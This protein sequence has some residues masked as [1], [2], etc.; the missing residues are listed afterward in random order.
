[1]TTVVDAGPFEKRLTLVV[2][3]QQLEE[4][5]GQAARKLG[6]DLKIPGFRPGRAP[7]QVVEATLGADRIRSEAI[8]TVLP[9]AVSQ[10]LSEEDLV[11]AARPQ[12]EKIED[13]ENGV[14]VEV[15]VA[16]WPALDEIPDYEGRKIE[17]ESPDITDEELDS[18][19][20]RLREQF[21][22]LET[23]GREAIVGDYIVLD[24]SANQGGVIVEEA[25]ANDLLYEVGS[26]LL[27]P[28]L[29]DH[30]TGSTAGSILSFDGA[31]PPSFGDRAGETV[32]YRILVKEVKRKVLPDLTDEWVDENTEHD[33]V[34]GLTDEL[35]TRL[36][37]FKLGAVYENYQRR[38]MDTLIS[39]LTVEIPAAIVTGEME[40]LLH[41]FVHQLDD[42]GISLEDYLQAT[43]LTQE[44]LLGDLRAQATRTVSTE[45]VLDAVRDHEQLDVSEEEM[46]EALAA[47]ATA[48]E[49]DPQK[50]R[51]T[52]LGG[53]QEQ[54]LRS[55]ILRRKALNA[56]LEAADPID[57]SGNT[58][59]FDALAEELAEAEADGEEEEE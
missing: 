50:V 45:L 31:L 16:L 34:G 25:A 49:E 37:Q 42:Q 44:Q 43:G 5:K 40:D 47:L 7:R 13:I 56:L 3:D 35:K 59:D 9:D 46:E 32:T 19:L 48:A 6:K 27:L 51:E 12:V 22:S 36:A 1:M 54:L 4:A 39:E 29:D 53:P 20:D 52:V 24:L 15:L 11:P 55:D 18:Q 41:R 26:G 57:D 2:T 38:L 17:V 14:S 23:V 33:T 10:A 28:G 58:I 8:D 30:A 21:A